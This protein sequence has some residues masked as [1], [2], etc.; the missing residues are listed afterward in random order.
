MSLCPVAS[1]IRIPDRTWIITS[2]FPGWT[3]ARAEANHGFGPIEITMSV[4]LV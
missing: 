3:L 1:H 2:T 4:W